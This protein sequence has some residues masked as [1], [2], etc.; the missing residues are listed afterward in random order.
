[1]A[2]FDCH[3]F[4]ESL[5]KGETF[6]ILLPERISS[7]HATPP[8]PVLYLLHGLSDDY[9]AWTRYTSLERY[10]RGTNLAVVMP[11]AGRSMYTDMACGPAYWQFISR[12]LP[13]FVEN[14]FPVSRERSETFAAGLSMGGYGAFKLAFHFPE[15]FGAVASLSGV[16]DVVSFMPECEKNISCLKEW[17]NIFGDISQVK[18][19]ENDVLA[20]MEKYAGQS[21]QLPR[22]Y[23]C[24]G[25]ED[26]LFPDNK[27]FAEIA[28]QLNIQLTFEKGPGD[29]NWDY[30][31]KQ[32]PRVIEW[33]GFAQ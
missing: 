10:L 20:L 22:F 21:D 11:D 18:G 8:Y 23:A 13:Q 31:D 5:K 9:S 16:L 17:Q 32:L 28:E 14:Y 19:S 26:F 6:R 15:R 29:H 3:F 27:R 30:W 12:E 33:L 25:E 4:S 2:Q 24:C 7:P 1:M